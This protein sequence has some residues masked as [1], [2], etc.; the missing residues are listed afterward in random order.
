MSDDF[1]KVGEVI[2]RVGSAALDVTGTLTGARVLTDGIKNGADE[3]WASAGVGKAATGAVSTAS[4]R[5][6]VKRVGEWLQVGKYYFQAKSG[7][8]LIGEYRG[9]IFYV[10]MGDRSVI[11]G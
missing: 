7:F 1:Q 3:A 9:G 4:E 11:D 6:E 2:H 5:V 8:I 10:V